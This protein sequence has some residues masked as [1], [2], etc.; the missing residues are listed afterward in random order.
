MTYDLS[1]AAVT[2]LSNVLYSSDQSRH[3]MNSGMSSLSDLSRSIRYVSRRRREVLP[4]PS[5][6]K[7]MVSRGLAAT[8][9]RNSSLLLTC[10]K[11]RLWSRSFSLVAPE[12][13]ITLTG[14]LISDS[15]SPY[16]SRSGDTIV[17]TRQIAAW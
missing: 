1:A 7:M 12:A 5:S 6:P 16:L 8:C 17:C 9:E 13:S 14:G 3:L 2:H 4:A 15:S 10:A 11:D